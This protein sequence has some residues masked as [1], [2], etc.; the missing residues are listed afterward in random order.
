[1]P[2]GTSDGQTYESELDQLFGDMD[3]AQEAQKGKMKDLESV[4]PSMVPQPN[5]VDQLHPQDTKDQND[6]K[7]FGLDRILQELGKQDPEPGTGNTVR[8][9]EEMIPVQANPGSTYQDLK[10]FYE[11]APPDLIHPKA[12]ENLQQV[13]PEQRRTLLW[14]TPIMSS[15]DPSMHEGTGKQLFNHIDEN[16][17]ETQDEKDTRW[18]QFKKD[19][20]GQSAK[21]GRVKPIDE[22]APNDWIAGRVRMRFTPAARQYLENLPDDVDAIDMKDGT[23]VFQLRKALTS[24]NDTIPPNAKPTAAETPAG[25][26]EPGNIDLNNRPIVK[27]ADG[28]F[29]TV[30]SMSFNPKGTQGEVLIP[31]ISDSGKTLSEEEAIQQYR[32]TGKHLG[33]FDTPENATAYAQKLHEDQAKQY[34]DKGPSPVGTP[35]EER[36]PSPYGKGYDAFIVQLEKA[37]EALNPSFIPSAQ[38]FMD[39]PWKEKLGFIL[40]TSMMLTRGT[41]GA[42]PPSLEAGEFF[43]GGIEKLD[44]AA[45]EHY[46]KLDTPVARQEY[47]Q[48]IKDKITAAAEGGETSTTNIT[49]PEIKRWAPEEMKALE[50]WAAKGGDIKN[51]PDELKDRSPGAIKLMAWKN[52]LLEAKLTPWTNKEVEA[53]KELKDKGMELKDVPDRL[54]NR[55]WEAI[56]QKA[57]TELNWNDPTFWKEN[58]SA[59]AKALVKWTNEGG[60]RPPELEGVATQ[61]INQKIKNLKAAGLIDADAASPTARKTIWDDPKNVE[62]LKQYLEDGKSFDEIAKSLGTTRGSVAGKVDRLGIQQGNWLDQVRDYYTKNP[63]ASNFNAYHESRG[64]KPKGPVYAPEKGSG[65]GGGDFRV[66]EV[67]GNKGFDTFSPRNTRFPDNQNIT[68]E[69]F[70]E[71]MATD[72]IRNNLVGTGKLTVAEVN[73]LVKKHGPAFE[74]FSKANANSRG[75]SASEFS[76]F[77]EKSKPLIEELAALERTKMDPY[78]RAVLDQ[79][80]RKENIKPVKDK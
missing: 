26:Q 3:R 63:G 48:M 57:R 28:T 76:R 54:M 46:R 40:A 78:D 43:K 13:T 52:D 47:A 80:K 53:L 14:D 39:A 77:M 74:E 65:S 66:T 45:L 58:D 69:N 38:Q 31:T 33:I 9:P 71:N 64:G 27:N 12:Y 44:T 37:S 59:A 50:G 36:T 51:I 72:I 67:E 10:P 18:E 7:N 1:M 17:R 79:K 4:G 30:S 61:N 23:I 15:K 49:N 35:L 8:Q 29:S 11:G 22:N 55:S 20:N 34:A 2:I 32:D 6:P 42:K 41:P 68:P 19:W 62:N 73:A 75:S 21:D 16:L 60:E 24:E 5:E 56:K 25:Q 70:G